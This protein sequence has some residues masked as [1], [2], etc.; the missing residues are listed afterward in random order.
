MCVQKVTFLG[1]MHRKS[2]ELNS[3]LVYSLSLLSQP[4]ALESQKKPGAQNVI[5]IKTEAAMMI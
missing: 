5:L 4:S 1:V 3:D 2:Q